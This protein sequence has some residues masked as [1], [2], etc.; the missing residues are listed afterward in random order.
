MRLCPLGRQSLLIGRR[1]PIASSQGLQPNAANIIVS[2]SR[3]PRTG[4]EVRKTSQG[5][6]Q[7]EQKKGLEV[8]SKKPTRSYPIRKQFIFESYLDL[9][10]TNK[11]CL[12]FKHQGL[13]ARE[14]NSIRGKIKNLSSKSQDT[15]SI[16][17]GE[18]KFEPIKDDTP[19]KI[20]PRLQ[21]LRTKM[22]LPVLKTLLKQS[23]IK[24][25][26]V[27]SL[28]YTQEFLNQTPSSKSERPKSESAAEKKQAK[29]AMNNLTGS[30]FSLSQTDFDPAQI[31]QVLEI[32]GAHANSKQA[33]STV[34]KQ[35]E[36]S[37]SEKIKFLIGYI[38]R[39]ICK[40]HT[41]LQR[42][43]NLDSLDS[44]RSQIISIISRF[45]SDL[46]L[47]LNLARASQLVNTLKGFQKTL[48]D[49]Q[50]QL[51]INQPATSTQTP[52]DQA[53]TPE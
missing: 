21:V 51:Q 1:L 38:D 41:D 44:S 52:P 18:F 26:T 47:N 49:D 36:D 20:V 3:N 43:S 40:D 16:P 5:S 25:E 17:F 10:T 11:V 7:V 30:V 13:T 45:S 4:K 14:W 46:L 28:I 19:T 8:I 42:F 37:Q 12:L 50:N 31:K 15:S 32:I 23:K 53:P 24:R 6:G 29:K 33:L 35:G 34:K 9:F 22:I 27:N 39:S 48:E 2:T